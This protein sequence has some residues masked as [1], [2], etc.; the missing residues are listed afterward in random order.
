[1]KTLLKVAVAV[2]VLF[3]VVTFA[4]AVKTYFYER[5]FYGTRIVSGKYSALL[6]KTVD[7]TISPVCGNWRGKERTL[8]G[9]LISEHEKSI[10]VDVDGSEFVLNHAAVTS[11]VL[12]DC[13]G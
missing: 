6:N 9:R 12:V 1:M 2:V 10:R 7:V 3:A 13:G 11:V 4:M 5:D 8:R